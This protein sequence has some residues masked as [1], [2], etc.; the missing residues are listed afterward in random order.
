MKNTACNFISQMPLAVLSTIDEIQ[1]YDIDV[2]TSYIH[3]VLSSDKCAL[4][5]YIETAEFLILY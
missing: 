1:S 4:L 2:P 3:R 5:N